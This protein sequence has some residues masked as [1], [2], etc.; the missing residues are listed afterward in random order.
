ME[1]EQLRKE[2]NHLIESVAERSQKYDGGKPI[3][4]LEISVLLAKINKIQEHLVILGYLLQEE[5]KRPFVYLKNLNQRLM[6]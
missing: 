5:E 2:L 6:K 4:S 3:P 1:I